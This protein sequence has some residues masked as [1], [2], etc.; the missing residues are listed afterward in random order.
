MAGLVI[1][2]PI[3]G[4][5][6]HV[7][8]VPLTDR[9]RPLVDGGDIV[10]ARFRVVKGVFAGS[11]TSASSKSKLFTGIPLAPR[12]RF[13]LDVAFRAR[14]IV[15]APAVRTASSSSSSSPASSPAR[16]RLGAVFSTSLN[17]VV[18]SLAFARADFL[19]D[20]VVI[21][22]VT[23]V[24]A[25]DSVFLVVVVVVVVVVAGST[26]SSS[27]SK[28]SSSPS[29]LAATDDRW[30]PRSVNTFFATL[31]NNPIAR[32]IASTRSASRG[33]AAPSCAVLKTF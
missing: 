33:D 20:V 1:P 30:R 2:T 14:I 13:P 18:S 19:R 28:S 27:K 9:P 16:R 12:F 3:A 25:R 4:D 11:R 31:P 29:S 10:C 5:A 6:T 21:I 24:F 23:G 8:G 7:P 32:C 17:T 15:V 22:S 26:S